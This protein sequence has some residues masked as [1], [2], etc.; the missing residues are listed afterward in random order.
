V[1]MR[2]YMDVRN[3]RA[4]TQ[5][6]LWLAMAMVFVL[7]PIGD[8]ALLQAEG[9]ELGRFRVTP[10]LS[11]VQRYSDNIY[12]SEADE[13]D[14]FYTEVSPEIKLDFALAPRNYLT[15]SYIGNF[16]Y[17]SSADNFNTEH[18][19][20]ELSWSLETNKGSTFRAGAS[21]LESSI[22]PYAAT[23]VSRDFSRRTYFGDMIL[24]T[25]ASTELG[26][27][28]ERIE[29]RFDEDAFEVDDYDRDRLDFSVVFGRSRIWPLL[30]QYRFVNQD[31]RD[32][33]ADGLVFNRDFKT[34]AVYTG[35]R[36]RPE[37]KVS[38]AFRVGYL[39]SDFDNPAIDE[40]SGFAMDID[41]IYRI[42]EITRV[43]L[44]GRRTILPVTL[45]D[46]DTGSYYIVTTG[47]V[48][49]SHHRWEKIVTR[50][51]YFYHHRDYEPGPEQLGE[52]IDREHVIEVNMDYVMQRW[53]SF[54]VGYRYRNNDSDRSSVDFKENMVHIGVTL[55]I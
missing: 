21:Q 1:T 51:N 20:G 23:G 12:L 48:R 18:H 40:F 6:V 11:V 15:L 28:Y 49:L 17:F 10:S 22:Q 13:E 29:R 54:V 39:W 8:K 53:I 30:L 24:M 32:H 55:S 3:F 43:A 35:A 14:D 7:S 36:W 46:R 9:L 41:V 26:A 38:G 19:R 16:Y 37:G 47:G 27:A 45:A 42:T 4:V 52:R 34:H 2:S 50:L 44:L 5:K 31:N 33:L 25:G